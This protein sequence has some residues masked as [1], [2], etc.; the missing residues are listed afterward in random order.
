VVDWDTRNRRYNPSSGARY[1]GFALFFDEAIGSQINFKNYHLD[2]RNYFSVA[3]GQVLAT[4]FFIFG[5]GDRAPFWRFASLGGRVHTRGYRRDRFLDEVLLAV[6]AE[7]RVRTWW[8]LGVHPFVGWAT[9]APELRK[10]QLQ[11]LK[12]TL[13]F[14]LNLHYGRN[15]QIIA[16]FDTAFGIEGVEFDLSLRQ[17]F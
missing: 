16:R 4:Q 10:M 5:T 7:Y 8:R 11:L 6:Q 12:P 2:L 1:Q 17:S 9:V 14:G 3:P 15:D 13:G